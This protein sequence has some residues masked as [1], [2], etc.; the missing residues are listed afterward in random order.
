MATNNAANSYKS[1]SLK[2]GEPDWK[3]ERASEYRDKLDPYIITALAQ[4]FF[5]NDSDEFNR[6][7]TVRNKIKQNHPK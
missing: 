3:K 7:M 6:L 2:V 1:I 5:D 4:K